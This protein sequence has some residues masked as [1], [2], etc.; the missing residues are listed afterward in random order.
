MGGRGSPGIE[1]E[2]VMGGRVAC[3]DRFR[4]GAGVRLVLRW[5]VLMRKGCRVGGM[6]VATPDKEGC[7]GE[8]CVVSRGKVCGVRG[9]AAGATNPGCRVCAGQGRGDSPAVPEGSPP[10]P[11]PLPGPPPPLALFPP[12]P[13]SCPRRQ[14]SVPLPSSR[15]SP[16]FRNFVPSGSFHSGLQALAPFPLPLCLGFLPVFAGAGRVIEW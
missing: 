16:P 6:A 4:R 9:R 1:G 7:L 5:S 3:Y 12:S 8:G 10:S 11:C 2:I 15:A 13:S 14:N